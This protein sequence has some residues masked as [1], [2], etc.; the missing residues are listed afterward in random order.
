MAGKLRAWRQAIERRE[1]ALW[2]AQVFVASLRPKE[3]NHLGKG[4]PIVHL[5]EREVRTR[6]E[7]RAVRSVELS[8]CTVPFIFRYRRSPVTSQV[9]VHHP[10]GCLRYSSI[11]SIQAVRSV[12][13]RLPTESR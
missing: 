13:Y 4:L 1:V 9:Y 5:S 8:C 2:G 6:V 10:D 7:V 3:G 11:S 12:Q